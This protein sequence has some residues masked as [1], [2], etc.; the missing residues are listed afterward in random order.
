[1]TLEER[2]KELSDRMVSGKDHLE[3]VRLVTDCGS[4]IADQATALKEANQRNEELMDALNSYSPN[5]TEYFNGYAQAQKDGVGKPLTDDRDVQI[6]IDI[7]KERIV[8]LSDSLKM[9]RAYAFAL[10]FDLSKTTAAHIVTRL[11][12][13]TQQALNSNTT[14]RSRR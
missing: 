11:K 10:E 2:V 9:I 8:G 5:M 12:A 3:V 6:V 4:L 1:M 7:Q 13:I 14:I